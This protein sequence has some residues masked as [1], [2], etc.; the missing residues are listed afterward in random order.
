MAPLGSARAT[1]V[2]AWRNWC[3][4]I[5]LAA[6]RSAL[7]RVLPMGT[8]VLQAMLW[9][10]KSLGASNSTL[11]SIVD[12]VVTRHRDANLPSPVHCPLAYSRLVRCLAHVLGRPHAHKQGITSLRDM[13]LS[14]LRSSGSTP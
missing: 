6:S 13:V 12:A 11:K 14:L 8:S 10:F 1:R 2:K 7:D 9:D 4:V 3:I 5:T